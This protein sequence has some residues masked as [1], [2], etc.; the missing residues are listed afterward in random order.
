MSSPTGS[1]A[2][3]AKFVGESLSNNN[4]SIWAFEFQLAAEAHNVWSIIDNT[5]TSP[6]ASTNPEGAKSFALRHSLAKSQIVRCI[7]A[8]MKIKIME[9]S[10]AQEM[11]NTL[12]EYHNGNTSNEKRTPSS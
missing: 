2:A 9:K 1:T 10:T 6:A 7:D 5:E 3:F 4:Y 12:K 8:E 11:W